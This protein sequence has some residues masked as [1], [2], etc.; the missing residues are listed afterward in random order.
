[1]GAFLS[2]SEASDTSPVRVTLAWGVHA[3]TASGALVGA[4]AL[5][6]IGAG[7]LSRAAFLMVV[8]LAIDSVD[9]ALA[10]AVRVQDVLPHV[11]GRRLDDMVD[12]LNYV[13]V[14]A[15]F[16]VAGGLITSWI[17]AA[18][19]I[20][21]SAYGFS[22]EQAKT[23]D[24]FFL[25]FPSYWN[26]VALYLWMLEVSAATG[27]ALVVV[28]AVLVFVPFK[29]VY[30]SKL[31]VLGR[32]TLVAG[33]VWVVFLGIAALAPARLRALGLVQL[34]LA[35]PAYYLLLSFRLG[36]LRRS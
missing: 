8:A 28:L 2:P 26:V 34:S 10:R 35:Y 13:I 30:P 19:P 21:A 33:A 15:V 22:Q 32:T 17:W 4:A 12:Y 27:T 36:G 14:P 31:R 25:G 7:E 9:G 16:L 24:D 6:A 5:L 1:V 23:E 18:V 11:D 20:L 29:Y 3:F